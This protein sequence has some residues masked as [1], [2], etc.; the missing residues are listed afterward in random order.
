MQLQIILYYSYTYDM[1]YTIIFKMKHILCMASG[2]AL[3]PSKEKLWVRICAIVL[4]EITRSCSVVRVHI[5][6]IK[7]NVLREKLI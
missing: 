3:P 1:I 5:F 4:T 2:S 6:L 7:Q